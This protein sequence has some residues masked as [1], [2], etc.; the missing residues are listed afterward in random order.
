MS[1]KSPY[2]Q[3]IGLI[4]RQGWPSASLESAGVCFES[5]KLLRF[6]GLR[7]TI[8]LAGDRNRKFLLK[9]RLQTFASH[10]RLR[11]SNV[12]S[13]RLCRTNI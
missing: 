1:E 12:R 9:G 11:I 7:G 8:A 3:R 5:V 4:K 2:E 10:R 13:F 6:G